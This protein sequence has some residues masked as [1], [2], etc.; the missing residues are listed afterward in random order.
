MEQSEF[1]RFLGPEFY[2]TKN[3]N[4]RRLYV[5]YRENGFHGGRSVSLDGD[6]KIPVYKPVLAQIP[7][8]WDT[9]L[10]VDAR[11]NR[12]CISL[13][14]LG[15]LQIFPPEKCEPQAA[16]SKVLHSWPKYGLPALPKTVQGFRGGASL[17][18]SDLRTALYRQ[19]RDDRRS[20][21]ESHAIRQEAIDTS[22][23]GRMAP[24]CETSTRPNADLPRPGE[25]WRGWVFGD[26]PSAR[27]FRLAMMNRPNFA[28]GRSRKPSK[29]WTVPLPEP[30]AAADNRES[31][32]RKAP[33]VCR[34][35]SGPSRAISA[36]QDYERPNAD[37]KPILGVNGAP[38][39]GNSRKMGNEDGYWLAANDYGKEGADRGR[40][41][42]SV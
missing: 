27:A 37:T 35:A 12:R 26:T 36:R 41:I 25:W 24:R 42:S 14:R 15:R 6:F 22:L 7:G 32:T 10:G 13:P 33:E 18:I 17:G 1:S 4:I 34:S 30:A 16:S 19:D 39:G 20:G 28:A 5:V 21:R 38:R 23:G 2:G 9:R 11:Y 40:P 8:K 29:S 3:S 31:K